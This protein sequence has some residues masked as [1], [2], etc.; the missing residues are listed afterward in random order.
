MTGTDRILASFVT[1]VAAKSFPLVV[2]GDFN[3][4]SDSDEIRA[5]TGR[6]ETAAPGFVLFDA[7]DEPG[8]SRAYLG[9]SQSVGRG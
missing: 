9:T 4:P 6:T 5:L 7:W 3:A 1:E 2:C 8:G